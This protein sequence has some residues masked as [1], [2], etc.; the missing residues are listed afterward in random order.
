MGRF[1]LPELIIILVILL[2]IFGAGRLPQVGGVLGKAFR[3]FRKG[4]SGT[5]EAASAKSNDGEVESTGN[6][7]GAQQEK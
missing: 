1:G 6:N 2:M 5:E 4:H 7:A 3:E